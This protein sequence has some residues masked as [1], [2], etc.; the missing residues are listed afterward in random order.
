M[1]KVA[2]M[3]GP[4]KAGSN[5]R[6]PAHKENPSLLGQG[7]CSDEGGGGGGGGES[8]APFDRSRS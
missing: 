6:S 2:G 5:P 8:N 4:R 3:T 1:F 7:G